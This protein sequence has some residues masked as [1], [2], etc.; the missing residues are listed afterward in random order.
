MT[1]KKISALTSATTPL[2][3][4]E[5]LPIVQSSATTKVAV[6]D[7][8]AGRAV[9]AASLTLTT[10]PLPVASGGTGDTGTAWTSYTPTIVADTGTFGALTVT[11]AKYKTIGKT[12]FL[13]LNCSASVA[14]GSPTEMRLSV[15]SGITL[16]GAQVGSAVI[17]NNAVTVGGV[18][19]A[20]ASLNRI[21]FYTYAGTIFI[22]ACVAQAY[23]TV[24]TA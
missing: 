13:N 21:R 6:S 9:S 18:C 23:I 11:Y 14:T 20:S 24:E 2:A 4:T 7:L 5:T 3:G 1:N 10:T 19:N 22:G 17:T 16:T 8:T 15:P 12:L